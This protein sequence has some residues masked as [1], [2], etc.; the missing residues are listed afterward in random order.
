MNTPRIHYISLLISLLAHTRGVPC[1]HAENTPK[2]ENHLLEHVADAPVW[3][4]ATIN[5][6]ELTIYLPIIVYKQEAGFAAFSSRKFWDANHHPT[7]YQGF[8]LDHHTKKVKALDGKRVYDFSFSKNAA[9]V[10]LSLLILLVLFMSLASYYRRRPIH[11][12][13]KGVWLLLTLLVCFVRDHIAKGN[14]GK[15]HYRRFTPY[16]L[17][18]FCFIWLNNFLGLL[19]GAAN[20][21]GNIST[22]LVLATFTF[23]V[24]HLNASKAYWHHIISPPDIP[25]WLYPIIIP[26]EILG[27]FTKTITLMMR[28]FANILAGHL[29]LLSIITI[30]FILK[31]IFASIIVVPIGTFMI[32]LKLGVSFL[33]AYLFTLLSA[34]SI[35]GAVASHE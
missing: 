19:P 21:T 32:I 2:E 26:T 34:L 30:I 13:P 15:K 5:G 16:L 25:K 29:V 31:T 12:A 7:S 20:V 14:I 1:C 22:T 27:L 4:F 24:T 9:G 23:L 33:Q 11:K 17:T 35:G 18:L 10:L 6:K 3:H 8:Y 28:L